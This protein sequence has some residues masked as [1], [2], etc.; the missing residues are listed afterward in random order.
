MYVN[1]MLICT[2]CWPIAAN[3]KKT[4]ITKIKNKIK[5]K[6][7]NKKKMKKNLIRKKKN[8]WGHKLLFSTGQDKHFVKNFFHIVAIS[9]LKRF[10]V[11]LTTF[12]T[13]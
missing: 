2:V 13:A 5:Q 8:L 7:K 4:K 9:G 3:E 6:M 11:K 12:S 1:L 10:F